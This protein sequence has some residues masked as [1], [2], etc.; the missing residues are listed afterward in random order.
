MSGL[1]GFMAAGGAMAYADAKNAE[2]EQRN[3]MALVLFDKEMDDLYQQRRDE[4]TA[5]AEEFKYQREIER[6]DYE[7]QRDRKDKL[8]DVERDRTYKLEDAQ[9]S[10]E[11]DFRK[12]KL[13]YG[14]DISREK[15]RQS[16]ADRRAAIKNYGLLNT[17]SYSSK[18]EE[19]DYRRLYDLQTKLHDPMT[20]LSPQLKE[21]TQAE[22]DRIQARIRANMPPLNLNALGQ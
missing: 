3:K 8:T 10:N 5:A 1:L 19:S 15:M 20:K 21:V 6:K 11:H 13:R 12:L 22:I 14:Y 7:Y 18:E 9:A 4:R 2:T 16:G 17:S